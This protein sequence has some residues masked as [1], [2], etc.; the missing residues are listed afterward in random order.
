M[1]AEISSAAFDHF[2]AWAPWVMGAIIYLG[3]YIAK[4]HEKPSHPVA[5]APTY[6]CAVCGRRGPLDQMIPQHHG[7]AVGYQC[8]QCAASSAQA[9]AH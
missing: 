5:T 8:A 4:R 7:G 3:F 2:F 1:I 6:A 9:T